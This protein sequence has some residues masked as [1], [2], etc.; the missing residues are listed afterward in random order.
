MWYPVV[1]AQTLTESTCKT[2][3]LDIFPLLVILHYTHTHLHKH[4]HSHTHTT[5]KT[6]ENVGPQ[7]TVPQGER[8]FRK[9]DKRAVNFV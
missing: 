2:P 7:G 1:T 3:R 4:T 5:N 9:M 8:P 6:H